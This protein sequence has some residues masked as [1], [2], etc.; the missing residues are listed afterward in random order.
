MKLAV[1]I[2][3]TADNLIKAMIAVMDVCL[4]LPPLACH[5]PADVCIN[6]ATSISF[7]QPVSVNI[8]HRPEH[9]AKKLI[10]PILADSTSRGTHPRT[11]QVPEDREQKDLGCTRSI[12]LALPATSRLVTW[13]RPKP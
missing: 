4:Q 6:V 8:N 10:D 12:G 11:V 7:R 3:F 1:I 5:L 9:S 2:P 13:A